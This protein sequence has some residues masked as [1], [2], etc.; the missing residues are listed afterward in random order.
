MNVILRKTIFLCFS[1][2]FFYTCQQQETPSKVVKPGS[3]KLFALLSPEKTGVD[4]TNTITMTAKHNVLNYNYLLNGGGVATSDFNNDQLPD[5]FLTGNQTEDKLY[6]NKG[7]LKFEDVTTKAGVNGYGHGF[8]N[9]WSTG[10]S[11]ADV[12]GDGWIDIYVCKS[13]PY[14][15]EGIRQNLLYINNGDGTFSEQSKSFGVNDE[16]YSTQ[17]TFFDYDKDGDPDLY[18]MNHSYLFFQGVRAHLESSE[19]ENFVKKIS[20]NLYRN[21][22]DNTF[23][24]VTK[25]AGLLRNTY[26]LGCVASDI[27]ND[28][29]VD[30]YTTSDYASP[31]YMFINNGDGT[32][33]EKIKE[34]TSHISFYGMGCDIADINNDGLNDIS[35]V[36]MTP[37]DQ[38]RSKTLMASMNPK[39]FYELHDVIGYQ[40]QY[41]INTLQLNNGNGKFSDIAQLAGVQKTD[42]SWANLLI[43]LDNDGWKDMLIANGYRYDVMDNDY[44]NKLREAKKAAGGKFTDQQIEKWLARLPSTKLK[45]VLLRNDQNLHFSKINHEW[46]MKEK[47]FSNGA[48]Y[49][50]FDQDGDLEIVFNNIDDQAYIYENL[51]NSNNTNNYLQIILNGDDKDVLGL[52]TKVSIYYDETQQFQELSLTRGYQ[53]SMENILHFGLGQVEKVD[54]IVVQWLDDK[55]Q[56]LTNIKANQRLKITKKD[57]QNNQYNFAKNYNPIF[58]EISD[59]LGVKFRHK[60]NEFDDFIKEI[61]LPHK[62]SQHGPHISVADV[63]ADG[64][65]DFFVGG[66]AQQAAGLLIQ[67]EDGSFRKS[68]EQTWTKDKGN[69]DINSLFF[70]ADQDGDQDLYVVSGG[71]EFPELHPALQDR[72]YLNNGQGQF[73]KDRNALPNITSSGSVVIDIDLDQDGD[74][75][76]FVGGRMIPG[77]YPLPDKSFIL[78]NEGGKFKNQTAQFAPELNDI[79]MVTT[80]IANDIDKDGKQDLII[81]G[82]W[83]S[84]RILKNSGTQLTDV[85][86]DELA[87]YQGW[88]SSIAAGDFDNDGD[89]D[90]I[91]GNLG[92]NYKYKASQKAPFH[93]YGHDFDKSGSI[94]IVLGYFNDG[95]CYPVRGRECS[96]Q[97]MPFI[98]DKFPTYNAF[99]TAELKDVYGEALNEAYHRQATHFASVFLKNEGNGQFK[100]EDLPVEAQISCINGIVVDDFN[101]DGQT[102]ALLA[103][104]LFVSE[105]E[106]PRA[107]AGVGVCLL[108]D[109]KGSFQPM[110]VVESGFY[111]PGDVKDLKKIEIKNKGKAI[112]V[113]NNDA[114]IQAF[115]A[116]KPV[117][118]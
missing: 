21:N 69:E 64:L 80:A 57:A 70:D 40:Y 9:S 101:N 75:D 14:Q 110:S 50:D 28:G 16:G 20:G 2:L 51:S 89:D 93:I 86:P 49:A 95:I 85:T 41:M 91:V 115:L 81:A 103:G 55:K 45:N 53:S 17:A 11:T 83:M 47:T 15:I 77:K 100:V 35:V 116:R 94:D 24:K 66:A 42:W 114:E 22:G 98:K 10:V 67:N 72:L 84:I 63:N 102:D 59:A 58:E 97:Q 13:G 68:S 99:A 52:N 32:F 73:T 106:T 33:S 111:A 56:V 30:L 29:W 36:D 109:G 39:R 105:V 7:D 44:I 1:V 78:I 5:L 82:E 61:L 60:E 48:A 96:S 27:N 74:L 117:V 19:D 65:D 88:W 108:G 76:L 54:S 62:N 118:R 104:N 38:K 23:T 112:L 79:G 46:G 3:K 18:V 12:N 31:D 8:D 43:D 107:D 87:K 92:K 37:A 4:F 71:N 26:G 113:A 6:I 34:S 25:E 90:F